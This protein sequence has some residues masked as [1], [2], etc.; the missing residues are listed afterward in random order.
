MKIIFS[1]IALVFFLST[2]AFGQ[3]KEITETDF[4]KV[5]QN[6]ERLLKTSSYRLTVSME[7]FEDRDKAGQISRS[8]LKVLE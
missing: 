6:A 5:E 1:L 3:T 7:Y 2:I 4:V 8:F